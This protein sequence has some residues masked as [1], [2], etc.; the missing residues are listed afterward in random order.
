MKIF[1]FMGRNSLTKSGVSWKLWKIQRA[2]RK[3][4]MLWGPAIVHKRRVVPAVSL[5]STT[6]A[7][8][9]SED[10]ERF[11]ARRIRSKLAKGYQRRT[12]T[13]R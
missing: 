5:Q 10:A 2:G 7:F 13:R 8:R 3:V 9:S 6:R 1:F 4:T 12:R 11:E